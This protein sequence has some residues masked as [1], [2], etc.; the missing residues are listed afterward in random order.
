MRAGVRQSTFRVRLFLPILLAV[1]PFAAVVVQIALTWRQHEIDDAEAAARQ[2]T[3]HLAAGHDASMRQARLPLDAVATAVGAMTSDG[4]T[5]ILQLAV[6]HGT[7][8]S[9][10]GVVTVDG[11]IVASHATVPSDLAPTI[12]TLAGSAAHEFAASEFV[13]DRQTRRAGIV[14]AEPAFG[15]RAGGRIVF[16]IVD[17]DWLRAAMVDATLPPGTAIAVFDHTGRILLRHPQEF[18]TPERA[19]IEDA[20][21]RS[22][23]AGQREGTVRAVSLDSV[24]RFFAYAPVISPRP[25]RN[26][27]VTAG[28][29]VTTATASANRALRNMAI[30]LVLAFTFAAAVAWVSSGHFSRQVDALVATAERL[31]NGDLDA[32]TRMGDGMPELARLARAIDGMAEAVR[33]R[34]HEILSRHNELVAH[35]R[36]FRAVIENG[37]DRVVLFDA[38]GTLLYAS[39]EDLQT[40]G[41]RIDEVVGHQPSEFVHE[42]D[43][44]SVRATLA[45]VAGS[46]GAS[47]EA[48]FRVRRKSGGWRTIRGEFSNMLQNPHARAIVGKY[49]DVT[50]GA[51]QRRRA[52]DQ[53]ELRVAERTAALTAA[54]EPLTK[55][56]R[57][58]EQSADSVF[59]TNRRGVI[60]YVNPAFEQMSG[61]TRAEAV[62]E[63]PRLVNSGQHDPRFF[64][65]LWEAILAGRVFR[66][67][68]TNRAKDGR[69][70]NEDQTIS[71]IRDADG[72]ITH[73]VSTG[74]DITGRQRVEQALRRLNAALENEAA[75]IAALLHDE[76]GQFLSSAHITLADIAR[77]VLP[78]MRSRLQRVRGHLEQAEEQLRRVSH[79]LHPRIVDDLGLTE[80]IRFVSNS[81]SRRSG[82]PVDVEI[83]VDR[84]CSRAV[85]AVLYRLVQE[86]LTN[87]SKH[88]RARRVAIELSRT[89]NSIVCSVQ[90]DGVGFD[91]SGVIDSSNFSLGLAVIRD[92]VEAVGGTFTIRSA[93]Q[94]GTELRA[95]APVE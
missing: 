77:D 14:F 89:E 26:L 29:P 68:V 33:A 42:D 49:R 30:A 86:A 10:V 80:A 18:E 87:I 74:R 54:N 91:A 81:F 88:A 12:R 17:A 78:E 34:E 47:A 31:T 32:R 60:E 8:Y 13:V 48:T 39:P 35:E 69:L 23:V 36:R 73:F 3:H 92:R 75:R 59:I 79:E 72:M 61:Y 41:Y 71:P 55:L 44:D 51:H 4:I 67:I 40:T 6:A 57:A 64:S 52:A 38:D 25:A 11:E 94:Q 58:I 43:R 24:P 53:L 37:A 20:L 56:S 46:P 21:V 16:G 5:S 90:D 85:E 70:F 63:T 83:T 95:T 65:A 1:V 28:V 50:E 7:P 9:N 2:F 19:T 22:I 15:A 84:S 62:G 93:P 45:H 76:A 27:Y 66:T 82:I